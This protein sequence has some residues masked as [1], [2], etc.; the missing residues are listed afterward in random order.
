MERNG[1]RATALATLLATPFPQTSCQEEGRYWCDPVDARVLPLAGRAGVNE[2]DRF[3]CE[4]DWGDVGWS[5]VELRS[6]H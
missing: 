4:E 2:L 1:R 3:G 6:G 5:C